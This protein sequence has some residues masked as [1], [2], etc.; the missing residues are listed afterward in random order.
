MLRYAR[1]TPL[2]VRRRMLRLIMFYKMFEGMVP[3][4]LS[5]DFLTPVT[6]NKHIIRPR[7]LSDYQHNNTVEKYSYHNLKC[8]KI[9]NCTTEQFKIPVFNKITVD[10]NHF[11]DISTT[12]ES[13]KVTPVLQKYQIPST[14]S[15]LYTCY[16]GP[17]VVY[18]QAQIQKRQHKITTI[19][20]MKATYAT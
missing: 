4:V 3:A 10:L 11:A 8:F 15:R 14:P 2:L 1:L 6:G 7:F 20:K 16:Q 9:K 12:A 5:H 18:S 17:C 13:F 19:F